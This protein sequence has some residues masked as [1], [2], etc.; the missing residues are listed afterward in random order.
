[1]DVSDDD[2]IE[3]VINKVQQHCRPLIVGLSSP[4]LLRHGRVVARH[5]LLYL[6]MQRRWAHSHRARRLQRR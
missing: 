4:H 6:L 3:H 2:T 5:K 1:M